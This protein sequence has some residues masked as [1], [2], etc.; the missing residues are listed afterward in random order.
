[1]KV[2]LVRPWLVLTLLF[3]LTLSACGYNEFQR[4]DE[5]VD[6]DG[7]EILNQYKRRNDLVPSLVET[8]KGEANFEKDTLTK[9]IEARAKASSIQITPD[10]L[11]NP[12]A[13][14]SFQAAQNTLG[15][16][17]SRLMVVSERYPALRANQSFADLRVQLEGTENRIALANNRYIKSVQNYNVM[18]RSFP[19]NLTA[20]AM[21]YKTK[22]G[23]TVDNE[24]E[25][26]KAPRIDF[27]HQ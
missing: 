16:A 17:I 1:M 12:E 4:L 15:G 3:C 7:K 21:G 14:K 26:K 25:I 11:N 20:M 8:V 22:E 19:S 9:V 24:A 10:T 6:A 2:L 18:V 27:G 23:F 5:Q 13:M